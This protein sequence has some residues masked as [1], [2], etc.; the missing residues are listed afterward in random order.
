MHRDESEISPVRATANS[1]LDECRMVLPGV[2]AL[3]GFQLVIVFTSVFDQR[4]DPLEQRLHLV[5]IALIALSIAAFMTPA[6]YL[7]QAHA[8][9]ITPEFARIS[10]RSL[11]LGVLSLAIGISLDFFLVACVI[12]RGP[13]AILL[14]IGLLAVFLALWVVLPRT[15]RPQ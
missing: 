2:Q 14:G 1:I 13:I 7:R 9:T 8:Y 5:A 11:L 10:T 3:F 6:A 12:L 15:G 4:L